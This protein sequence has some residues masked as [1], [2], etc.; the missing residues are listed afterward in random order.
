MWSQVYSCDLFDKFEKEG[1]MNPKVGLEYRNLILAPG[2]S[3]DSDLS[4]KK[5]LGRD[6]SDDA[7]LRQ[8]NFLWVIYY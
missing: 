3:I 6:P 4:L 5:F 2:G 7:F 1:I 8:N